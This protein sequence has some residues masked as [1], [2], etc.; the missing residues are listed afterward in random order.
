MRL[1][2]AEATELL[3]LYPD[4]PTD[5]LAYLQEHGWGSTPSGHTLYSGPVHPGDVYP[6]LKE[7]TG[8]ILIG[9]DGMGYCLGY[10]L[11]AL[12]YG[13]FSDAGEWSHFG[14]GFSLKK[15]LDA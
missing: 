15:L 7:R 8:C 14:E 2:S 1:T 11:G 9:D 13:E 4:L 6:R 3:A 5:Y 10:D 12:R